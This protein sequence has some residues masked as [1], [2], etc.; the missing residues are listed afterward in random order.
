MK[1]LIY[2]FL[3]VVFGFYNIQAQSVTKRNCGTMEH[4]E[5]QLKAD[6]TLKARMATIEQQTQDWISSHP[7][8]KTQAVITIPVVVHVVWNTAGQNISDAQ[9][10]SQIAVLNEDFAR[11]NA[12][13]VNTPAAWSGIAANTQIQ[14]CMAQRDPN[15][16]A[17]TGIVRKQTSTASFSSNDNIKHNSTGGD[18]AWPA[19]NYLNL[20]SG[21]LSGSLLGYAQFPGGA[22]STDGVVILYNAFGRVGN[23]AAPFHL[24]RTATHEVGHWLNLYHIWGDDGTSCSGSDQVTDTPN[25]SSENY[26]CPAYPHT[27]ACSASS[28]GVMFMNYMDYTDDGCMNIFTNGQSSRMNASLNGTRASLLTSLGCVPPTGGSCGTPGGLNATSITTS[29]A[30]LNWSAVSG[31]TSYNVQYRIVGA[32]SWTSTTSTTVSKGISGLNAGANFEFQVQA[33]CSGSSSN[34]SASGTFTTVSTGCTDSFEPNNTNATAVLVPL[35]VDVT[36]LINTGTDKD[37]FKFTTTA[38][39]T[40]VKI[41]LTNLPADYDLKLTNSGGSTTYGTSQNGGTTS[42]TIIL[43]TTTARTYKIKVYPYSTSGY[44]PTLC[45]TLRVSTGSSNFR[46][47]SSFEAIATEDGETLN[48]YPNPAKENLTIQFN[49]SVLGNTDLRIYDMLGRNV[50]S[51]KQQCDKGMNKFDMKLS[52]LNKGVYFL[53]VNNGAEKEIKKLVI[54]K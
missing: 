48:I 24:G 4:L 31:A 22:A 19:G 33:V 35:N 18:D 15:G 28:P 14:F 23:V 37:F 16:N 44:N 6:P 46:S 13:K 11:L 50:V 52:E 7:Q 1:K 21:N 12:D 41:T 5:M 49:S 27:D 40:K 8:N 17:T 2:V 47:E 43:N 38:P 32:G 9:V 30:T 36:G 39:N 26:S 54:D 53:E 29:S 34:F 51:Q 42:E 45:Y 3:F 10:L 25:Q 20:W